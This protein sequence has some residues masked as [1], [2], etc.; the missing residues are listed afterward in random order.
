M[1][2]FH[3]AGFLILILMIARK[4]E[5]HVLEAFPVGTSLMVLML[6]V[7]AFFG[8]LS[9]SDWIA[10]AA[11][12]AAVI[13]MFRIPKEKRRVVL[14]SVGQDLSG[15]GMLT[16]LAMVLVVTVCTSGKVVNWW[17]DYNFWATDVKSLFY[18]DGFAGKYANAAPEFGDYP[19]GTQMIKWWFLHLSPGRFREGLMFAG[20]Y[21]MN[22]SFLFP[23]LRVLKKRNV[24][25]M[26][27]GAAVVWL[28]PA[29]AEVFWCDGCCADLTM[30]LVYGSFLAAAAD[31][32]GCSRPFYYMRQACFL[33]VLVLC[34]N[35]G[36]IWAAFGLLFDY[37]YHFLVHKAEN[38]G[39]EIKKADRKKLFIITLLPVVTESSWLAF[40]VFNR[41]V[42]KLTGTAIQMATGGMN[43]PAYQGDMVK[44]FLEA[45]VRWP[46]HRWKT[47]ALDLSPLSLYLLI[48]LFV[49]L[50]YKYHKMEKKTA[51]YVGGFLAVSGIVFYSVNLISHLT[52]FAVETQYLEP[53]GM[54]SSIERYGAPF[55]IGGLYLIVFFVL[56]DSKSA[57]GAVLCIVFV[58]L[59]T[60]YKS[61]YR[62]LYGY[63][64]TAGE[65]LAQREEMIDEKAEG[66]LAAVDT[67]KG[68]GLGRVLYL[69]DISDVSWV[70]NTYVNF[71]AAP[72]SVLY[73]NVD[74]S[75]MTSQDIVN[76]V[77]DAHAE[78]L[79]VDAL[80]GNGEQIF[81]VLA[82]GEVFE[83]GCLYQV[84]EA[85][86]GV[87]LVKYEK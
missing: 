9:F 71:E 67:G 27:A 61:A 5:C 2:I 60:D 30:A 25:A 70:R 50:L 54:V 79:Y 38:T 80:Q 59:T 83:Y 21:F 72:V 29:V 35:T 10:A 64:D 36:F 26:A 22:L 1:V 66:F 85:G 87:R 62:A 6:Y 48:L 86:E 55:M 47:I 11:V 77:E 41:R 3:I 13:Y 37:G 42:A 23:F 56:K 53:Y 51:Y 68:D 82:Q 33:M 12:A 52:I 69:R 81:D 14:K 49:F 32:K 76:A 7:L 84:M 16:A 31:R 73:G 8:A 45:F 18:L 65:T 44:A 19:P 74:A 40:C 24:F 57:F 34:K 58:L 17:D 43:I 75:S 28:F 46:L 20:Y 4:F 15:P 63:R 39:S 78:F